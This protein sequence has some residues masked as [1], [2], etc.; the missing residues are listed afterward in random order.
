M[1]SVNFLELQER[2]ALKESF[3]EAEDMIIQLGIIKR[4]EKWQ[5]QEQ[6]EREEFQKRIF[7]SIYDP[8]YVREHYR[9]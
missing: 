8:D 7:E 4:R 1:Q 3:E 6:R 9:W 2:W 5:E